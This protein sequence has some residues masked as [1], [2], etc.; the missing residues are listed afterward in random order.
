MAKQDISYSDFISFCTTNNFPIKWELTMQDIDKYYYLFTIDAGEK[1]E[2]E[3]NSLDDTDDVTDFES[4]Y[5]VENES[6]DIRTEEKIIKSDAKLV[7][8]NIKELNFYFTTGDENSLIIKNP[9][10]QGILSINIYPQDQNGTLT[11]GSSI[12]TGLITTK[13]EVGLNV[14]G[15]G[16]PA[17]TVIDSIDSSSQITLNNNVTVTGDQ[18]LTFS[19]S[20]G[21]TNILFNPAFNFDLDGGGFSLIGNKPQNDTWIYCIMAPYIPK[22]Y[23]GHHEFI[24]GKKLIRDNQEYNMIADAKY[25]VYDSGNPYITQILVKVEHDENEAID[26]EIRYRLYLA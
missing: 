22:E 13:L 7:H 26:L 11:T 25:F 3:I 17:D 16:I 18:T 23:G 20:T 19:K 14:T 8:G 1:I 2:C 12:I 15:T 24:D 21:E 10:Y 9:D 6:I 4:N 5:K